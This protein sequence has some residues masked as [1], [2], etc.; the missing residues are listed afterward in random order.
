VCSRPDL[1]D[2]SISP[3][4]VSSSAASPQQPIST[5]RFSLHTQVRSTVLAISQN[6]CRFLLGV[7]ALPG[8]PLRRQSI[9]L[10][11]LL[12]LLVL[13]LATEVAEPHFQ[14]FVEG[15]AAT[16]TRDVT[17][18]R[19]LSSLTVPT[20]QRPAGREARTLG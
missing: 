12:P 19:E 3:S 6:V 15:A 16:S 11:R 5:L 13:G 4:V 2:H 8:Q 17:G 10:I 9:C 14:R 7:L 1:V 18:L 20:C